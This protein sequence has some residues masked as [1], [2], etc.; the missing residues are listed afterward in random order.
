VLVL[1]HSIKGV[2][3]E[4]AEHISAAL[5][6]QATIAIDNALQFHE[7]QRLLEELRLA[8]EA[9]DE[10]L[11]LVS[12][13]LRTPITTIFGGARL[14]RSR[15]DKLDEES[16]SDV[17][18]D[19]EREADRLHRI[20]EDLLVLARVELGQEIVM[21]PVL[22]RRVAERTI[23]SFS[24]RRAGRPIE[25]QMDNELAPVSASATYMEQILRNLI[26]NAD[27]YSPPGE[28]I[29]IWVRKEGNDAVVSVMDRGPG[30]PQEEMDLIFER[31]Y[32]SSGT[33]AQA[34]G[35]GI[36]LTVCKRL[37]D[38]QGGRIWAEARDGGGLSI[39]LA[40][41]VVDEAAEA[42]A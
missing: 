34:S 1:T 38:A 32:R 30:L 29:D 21:E 39:S 7:S 8:N 18:E 16:R 9:K 13:E 4:R 24:R 40:L 12:H 31:F 28:P 6:A 22:L 17:L 35:A 5:A 37:M 42:S 41:P 23:W 14:L 2:F 27:K 10:F 25:L 36:G 3:T 20:V 33:S 19:I 26:T 11:G 15:G